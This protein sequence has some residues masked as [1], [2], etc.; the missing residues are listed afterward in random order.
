MKTGWRAVGGPL[1]RASEEARTMVA[2]GEFRLNSDWALRI[3]IEGVRNASAANG[4]G[5]RSRNVAQSNWGP[6][7]C[8]SR[9]RSR[10]RSKFDSNWA[11]SRGVIVSSFA[12][13]SSTNPEMLSGEMATVREERETG[14]ESN[15]E[16]LSRSNECAD[17]GVGATERR[18]GSTSGVETRRSVRGRRSHALCLDGRSVWEKASSGAGTGS[19]GVSKTGPMKQLGISDSPARSVSRTQRKSW[20]WDLRRSR[21]QRVRR[22]SASAAIHASRACAISL[23]IVEIWF[24]R[25]ISKPSREAWEAVARYS[26][27]G[28]AAV[29]MS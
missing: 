13:T 4:S 24:N 23:R 3:K 2:T 11:S 5:E 12:I 15:A 1:L 25:A 29:V 27:G 17:C 9:E 20:S 18:I 10:F 7:D 28:W 19:A 22:T 26:K 16:N 8:R 21:S 14:A 6:H